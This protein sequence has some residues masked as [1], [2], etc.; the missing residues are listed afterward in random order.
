MEYEGECCAD[1]TSTKQLIQTA[2]TSVLTQKLYW[3]ELQTRRCVAAIMK[4]RI[5]NH[6]KRSE[7]AR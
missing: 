1:F 6:V 4:D 3:I 2:E 5:E 7:Q